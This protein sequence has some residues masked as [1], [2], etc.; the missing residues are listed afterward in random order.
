MRQGKAG[1]YCHKGPFARKWEL[2]DINPIV[3]I[4]PSAGEESCSTTLVFS[5]S[6]VSRKSFFSMQQLSIWS[7]WLRRQVPELGDPRSRLKLK[8]KQDND[9]NN[10]I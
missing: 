5:F 3:T 9:T 1:L 8:A 7:F 6:F 10:R 4:L 2:M